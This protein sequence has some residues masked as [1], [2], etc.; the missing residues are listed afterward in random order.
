MRALGRCWRRPRPRR[1]LERPLAP[2][3]AAR[4]ARRRACASRA[5]PNARPC[6]R[7]RP[8]PAAPPQ[9]QQA[10]ALALS[11]AGAPSPGGRAPGAPRGGAAP[12]PPPAPPGA[13][14]PAVWQLISDNIF[15]H[16]KRK[17]QDEDDIMVCQCPPTWRGGDGCGPNCLNRMLCIECTDDFCPC[18]SACTNQAFTRKTY[19]KLSV[20]RGGD[21]A[22]AAACSG[23]GPR[24]LRQPRTQ[25]LAR[26][27]AHAAP[28]PLTPRALLASAPSSAARGPRASACSRRRRSRR[29]SS[30]SSTSARW[31]WGGRVGGGGGG[32]G[33]GVQ[34][35]GAD[36][37][38]AMQRR[39]RR[40]HQQRQKAEASAASPSRRAQVLEEEEY[41]RR[42]D[43]Y[44][45][46]GQRHYYFMNVGNGE[47][48]DACRKVGGEA[49]VGWRVA[50]GGA[51]T[52][53]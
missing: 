52:T 42:K 11:N 20:V 23:G 1:A 10:A 19:A 28:C 6:P 48:I 50:Q 37:C 47:V 9:Q 18:E 40:Q 39:Q 31:G 4:G 51:T 26:A 45:N 44:N 8:R 2:F 7:P 32:G 34:W 30:S 15:S 43:Y 25:Q 22:G 29:G 12:A 41:L 5:H 46:T 53:T 38:V 21:G 14:L 13:K 33:G 35:L 27:G 17:V 36:R 49:G 3:A 16:R 24:S